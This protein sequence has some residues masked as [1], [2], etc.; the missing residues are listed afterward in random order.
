MEFN[1]GFKG[2]S[3]VSATHLDTWLAKIHGKTT[4]ILAVMFNQILQ[5]SEPMVMADEKSAF[6]PLSDATVYDCISITNCNIQT[7]THTHI[8]TSTTNVMIQC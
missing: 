8:H 6:V 5:C 4:C 1:S 7:H 3:K 2:L